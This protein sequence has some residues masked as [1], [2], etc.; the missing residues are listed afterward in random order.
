M[1]RK[2]VHVDGDGYIDGTSEAVGHDNPDPRTGT[3]AEPGPGWYDVPM[4]TDLSDV[5]H[6]KFDA[7]TGAIGANRVLS[8]RVIPLRT[9][10]DRCT[11]A[12]KTAF[13]VL[14]NNDPE[15]NVLWSALVSSPIVRLDDLALVAGLEAVKAAN[16]ANG[17]QIWPDD[18]TADA[19]IAAIRG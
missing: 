3:R 15:F 17:Y 11:L 4:D 18:A 13:K 14:R 16:A 19:R 7:E 6:R 9:F 12:E 8:I 10:L 1:P 5:L 2:L